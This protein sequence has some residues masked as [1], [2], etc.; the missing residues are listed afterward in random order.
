MENFKEN[1]EAVGWAI[2]I[3]VIAVTVMY[4]SYVLIPILILTI[5]GVLTFNVA[6]NKDSDNKRSSGTIK[7]NW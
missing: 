2:L 7:V 1:I 4:L 3:C 6:K 5:L